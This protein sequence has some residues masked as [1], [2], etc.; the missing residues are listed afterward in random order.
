MT[1]P[2]STSASSH[3]ATSILL[4]EDLE[5]DEFN[6]VVDWLEKIYEEQNPIQLFLNNKPVLLER[7]VD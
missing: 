7:N 1:L 4:H 6:E 5:E 2:F 3:V